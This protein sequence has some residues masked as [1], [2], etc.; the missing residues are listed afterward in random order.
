MF[1]KGARPFQYL[2]CLVSFLAFIFFFGR[3]ACFE[4][5]LNF[6]GRSLKSYELGSIDIIFGMEHGF[7]STK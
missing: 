1:V 7:I 4:K 3:P 6:E 2:S 5:G